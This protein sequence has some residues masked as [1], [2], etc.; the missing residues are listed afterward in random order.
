MTIDAGLALERVLSDGNEW[1][2]W[3]ALRLAG[4]D[5][6]PLPPPPGQDAVGGWA[7][8][9]GRL[10]PGATGLALCRFRL[11]GVEDAPA[12]VIGADWLDSTQTP[13]GAW[14]DAPDDVPGVIDDFG[15]GRVWATSSS[16][17]A[18][19]AVGRDPGTRA[20]EL[21][22]SE[23][24]QEG[25]FTGGAYPTYAAAGA[26]WLAEGARSE[27]AE[28]ALRWTREWADEWWGPQERVAALVFWAAAGVPPEHPSVEE[29]LDD[30]TG[31]APAAGWTNPELTVSALEVIRHFV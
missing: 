10:S 4:D 28:W 12:A 20:F 6:G 9:T 11:I 23:A 18:L 19:L 17:C 16:A 22:R 26:Y 3:R 5:P 7:G 1:Q 31:G 30:L 25:H 21:L 15:A 2:S 8:P 29:F 14:L 24:D 13:A 27:T